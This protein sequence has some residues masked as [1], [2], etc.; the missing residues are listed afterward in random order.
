M[1]RHRE[2]AR[3][4]RHRTDC[5][6]AVI[7]V[8]MA[9]EIGVRL[10]CRE[11]TRPPTRRCLLDV[12]F[13]LGH[14]RWSTGH[15]TTAGGMGASA[16]TTTAAGQR[17]STRRTR[18]SAHRWH[19]TRDPQSRPADVRPARSGNRHT[20]MCPNRLCRLPR[21][22]TLALCRAIP[23]CDAS[24]CRAGI[25]DQFLEEPRER[26][27]RWDIWCCGAAATT[28]GSP[29]SVPAVIG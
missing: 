16:S 15:T 9:S 21:S 29:T 6:R 13:Q 4:V 24:T 7:G 10:H 27:C 1:A 19:W 11:S 20:A 28:A 5:A 23:A 14:V 3:V 25:E 8:P 26:G 2:H 17:W 22:S 18:R 12:H